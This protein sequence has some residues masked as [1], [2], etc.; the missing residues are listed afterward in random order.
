L[1]QKLVFRRLLQKESE[2]ENSGI[3]DQTLLTD[4]NRLEKEIFDSSISSK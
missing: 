4:K 3:T 1:L 2:E